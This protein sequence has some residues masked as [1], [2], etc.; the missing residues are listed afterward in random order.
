MLLHDDILKIKAGFIPSSLYCCQILGVLGEHSSHGIVHKPGD[1]ALRLGAL[2]PQRS[3]QLPIDVN[4]CSLVRCIHAS[5]P[6][7]PLEIKRRA[8]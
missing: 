2:Q 3:M 6:L 1:R 7:T 5:I 8:L 4:R